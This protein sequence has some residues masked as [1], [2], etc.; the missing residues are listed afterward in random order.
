M[1]VVY[2]IDGDSTNLLML[3]LSVMSLLR[4][5]GSDDIQIFIMYSNVDIHKVRSVLS[6]IAVGITYYPFDYRTVDSIFPELPNAC[7]QRLYH[8]SLSRW[9]I[10]RLPI[11]DCWYIDTDIIFNCDIH[12]LHQFL[13][14]DTLFMA[15]N[16]KDYTENSFSHT[17]DMNGGVL[18]IDIEKFNKMHLFKKVVTFYHEH[19]DRIK[20]VNQTCYDYLFDTYRDIC[21]TVISD[22]YNIRMWD[23]SKYGELLND[24]RLFHFNGEDKSMF[25]KVYDSLNFNSNH[26]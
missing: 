9:F 15:F 22:R 24:I 3:R 18:Y 12:E 19:A 5:S 26:K 11:K 13:N 6:D 20:Y 25:F 8:A 10:S 23:T 21:N 7:N 1:N 17:S 14:E 2:T 4:N 16:R